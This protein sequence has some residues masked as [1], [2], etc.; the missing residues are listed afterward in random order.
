MTSGECTRRATLRGTAL[1]SDFSGRLEYY[2]SARAR[3][4]RHF[5]DGQRLC[6]CTGS[7]WTDRHHFEHDNRSLGHRTA[8]PPLRLGPSNRTAWSSTRLG[9]SD[10]TA[11]LAPSSSDS[12][13][14]LSGQ[15][16][17]PASLVL[18]LPAGTGNAGRPKF[19]SKW[20]GAAHLCQSRQCKTNS[21]P[22]KRDTPAA[23]TSSR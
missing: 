19:L 21:G 14:G 9:P 12:W 4:D 6:S 11:P 1:R 17:L 8:C 16:R 23:S 22:N 18:F 2:T 13:T 15:A 20:K 3:L 5:L 7:W 10:R